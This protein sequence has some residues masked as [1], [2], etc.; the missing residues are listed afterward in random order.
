MELKSAA[1]ARLITQ[2]DLLRVLRL[3]MVRT[4]VRMEIR[5]LFCDVDGEKVR[6]CG[7]C[8]ESTNKAL[9]SYQLTTSPAPTLTTTHYFNPLD[10]TLR[11]GCSTR[12]KNL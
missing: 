1:F 12:Q 2:T 7:N 9:I 11:F 6:C 10:S 5:K 3:Q 8:L 4:E